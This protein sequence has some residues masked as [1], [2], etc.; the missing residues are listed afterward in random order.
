M[1]KSSDG[2]KNRKYYLLF[3]SHKKMVTV[4]ATFFP[5]AHYI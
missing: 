3:H 2:D 5:I 4:C 1:P